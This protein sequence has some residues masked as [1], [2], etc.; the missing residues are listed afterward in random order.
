M[1]MHGII[2]YKYL[3]VN[4][5]LLLCLWGI[6][7]VHW[8]TQITVKRLQS[9]WSYIWI[10]IY[11][12]YHWIAFYVSACLCT[13]HLFFSAILFYCLTIL[14]RSFLASRIITLEIY[15]KTT[16]KKNLIK[17]SWSHQPILYFNYRQVVAGFKTNS[18][19]VYSV[20]NYC[21]MLWLCFLRISSPNISNYPLIV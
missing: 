19:M 6:Y 12:K 15:M 4:V 21:D 9:L 2:I 13:N 18:N 20:I 5:D 7:T 17:I 14:F 3:C 16:M 11:C 8:Y 10:F 1:W